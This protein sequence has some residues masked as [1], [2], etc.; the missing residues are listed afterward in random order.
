MLPAA[1]NRFSQAQPDGLLGKLPSPFQV[2]ASDRPFLRRSLIDPGE[3]ESAV[4]S[5]NLVLY[6]FRSSF[7]RNGEEYDNAV[8]GRRWPD[9]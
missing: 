8:S 5:M 1:S 7:L 4:Q 6:S 2:A 3:S 9:H